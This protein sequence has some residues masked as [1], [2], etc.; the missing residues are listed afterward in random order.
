[1]ASI[2]PY[3][4]GYRAQIDMTVKGERKRDSATFRTRREAQSW[5]ATRERDLREETTTPAADR[6]TLADMLREYK[7][8][9]RGGKWEANRINAF[10]RDFPQYAC[11]SLA[12]MGTP[13]WAVWRDSRLNG[14]AAPNGR[15]VHGITG[16]S[17][18]RELAL[19][20]T[21]YTVARR[22]WKWIDASPITDLKR[23]DENPA[24]E[25]LPD[26]WREVRPIVRWLGYRT[27]HEPV[28]LQQEV[29]LAFLLAM[30]TA[31]RAQEL[32]ELGER[33]LDV[34]RGV[35]RVR[36]KMQYLTGKPREIPLTRHA[37]RLLAP[38]AHRERCFRVSAASLDALFRKA[39]KALG[40]TGLHFH[41]SRAYAI[42][43]LARKVDVMTLSRISGIKDLELLMRVYYRETA[44]DVAD[45][46]AELV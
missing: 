38:V 44:Q 37:L 39:K 36:H 18:L 45:R 34:K 12:E 28:T 14:F 20:S 15:R 35:A 41:D 17:V 22:E 13:Q 43:T 33:T 6:Y 4:D 16:S 1:M 8:S 10:I 30:R 7:P 9:E 31:M 46:L 23:P 40:I 19:Y 27:G 29:A 25:R 21:I 24:R 2:Q 26:P 11:L 5:A 32:R 3:K 42:T